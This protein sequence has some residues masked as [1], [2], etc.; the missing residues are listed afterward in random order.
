LLAIDVGIVQR[1]GVEAGANFVSRCCDP[2]LIQ[3]QWDTLELG[4]LMVA[5]S[6]DSTKHDI[7][8]AFYRM[9]AIL[10]R[11]SGIERCISF[12]KS[13]CDPLSVLGDDVSS[14]LAYKDPKTFLQ[15]LLQA[16]RGSPPTYMCAQSPT[17]P[18]HE[19]EWICDLFVG[20]E[21]SV[22]ASA[23][24]K[25]HAELKAA[26]S[27]LALF[28]SNPLWSDRLS[29][30]TGAQVEKLIKN[31]RPPIFSR[32]YRQSKS[33]QD[34]VDNMTKTWKISIDSRLLMRA[35]TPRSVSG[36]RSNEQLAFIGSFIFGVFFNDMRSS[37]D[38]TA[39]QTYDCFQD[40]IRPDLLLS[41][42]YP[43]AQLNSRQ[44]RV[45]VMQGIVAAA[46]L[47]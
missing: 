16:N 8:R 1:F 37:Q 17:S 27:M 25:R 47:P 41:R 33:G 10:Y 29:V 43:G 44:Q 45:D 2:D 34:F 42:L 14:I 21:M 19:A 24:T 39:A 3:H 20:K 35:L 12:I 13:C 4:P 18:N 40:A 9:L 6:H 46:F 30:F 22:T 32:V 23:T 28:R 15:E 7:K 26:E 31:A 5:Y 11:C 36:R 38:V